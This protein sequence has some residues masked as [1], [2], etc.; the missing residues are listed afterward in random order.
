MPQG[1]FG[2][3]E[4]LTLQTD[5]VAEAEVD[6]AGPTTAAESPEVEFGREGDG[7]QGG[8]EETG[9]IS[10]GFPMKTKKK[11]EKG[12]NTSAGASTPAVQGGDGSGP[13]EDVWA[14]TTTKKKKG[15]RK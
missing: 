3:T 15:K 10:W 7:G 9:E 11:K 8:E 5:V 4:P 14:T 13:A 6:T 2:P 12:G 1:G